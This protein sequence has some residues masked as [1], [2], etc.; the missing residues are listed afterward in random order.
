MVELSNEHTCKLSD[1]VRNPK[2]VQGPD[3]ES[4]TFNLR[5]HICGHVFQE[6][7]VKMKGLWGGTSFVHL[8]P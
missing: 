8:E 5:C 6:I 3:G 7:Y 4:V 1:L 2:P